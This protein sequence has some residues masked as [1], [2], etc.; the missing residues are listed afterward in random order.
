MNRTKL[1]RRLRWA[2]G[3]ALGAVLAA[4]GGL[5]LVATWSPAQYR[6]A[7]MPPEEIR[8]TA[9]EFVELLSEFH[10]R[11]QAPEPF[12][13]SL[14]EEGLNAY[15]AS[16]DDIGALAPNGKPGQVRAQLE[17]AGVDRPA[18][19]VGEGVLTVMTR[20]REH[21]K[22]VSADL[23]FDLQ[24]DG[25]LKVRV[26]GVRVGRLPVPDSLVAQGLRELHESLAPAARAPM[27]DEEALRSLGVRDI[28]LVVTKVLAA[29]VD[30][31]PI[32][33]DLPRWRKRVA[34]IELHDGTLTV[35]L[36]VR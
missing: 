24:P 10:N 16:M 30:G 29:V 13:V 31:K 9:K 7:E 26:V 15:L 5:Y 4:A 2:L 35:R 11:L 21:G 22:V 34:G 12:S 28:S 1:R 20:L 6:P 18:V 32:P 25:Q 19:A 8:Q 36:A 14:T 33:A 23:A 27:P 17:R 3:M